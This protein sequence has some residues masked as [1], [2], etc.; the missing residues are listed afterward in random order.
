MPSTEPVS[1]AEGEPLASGDLAWPGEG[2]RD[3][4]QRLGGSQ[5]LGPLG[6]AIA[7]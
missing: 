2:G 7:A 1:V 6:L 3:Q 5:K 4:R